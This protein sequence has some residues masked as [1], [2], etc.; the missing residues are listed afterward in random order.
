MEMLVGRQVV[1]EALRAGRRRIVEIWL[2]RGIQETEAVR[3]IEALCANA[4]IPL[5]QVERHELDKLEGE[6]VHQGVAARVSPYPYVQVA[7]LLARAA[8]GGSDV[9]QRAEA[10]F[11]LA[12]DSVQDPQNLGAILRTAEAVGVHGVI[13]PE[14]RAA[15][16][17]PAVGR[18]SAGAAEHLLIAQVTNLSRTLERLKKEGLWVVGLEQHPRAQDYRSVDFRV[19][20]VLVL[21]GEG[22]GMRRLVAETCDVLVYLPMRGQVGSLNV[23]VAAGIIL[24]HAWAMRAL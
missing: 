14:R 7:D 22:T 20:L 18:A 17:T 16:V 12:L 19:P 4:G 2:A 15:S 23:S 1:R 11:L 3:E 10:P 13:L 6:L 24:Y 21:G 8:I 5:R 9:A